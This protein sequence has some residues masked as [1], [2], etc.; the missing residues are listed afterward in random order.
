M[1]VL[2]MVHMEFIAHF[3]ALTWMKANGSKIKRSSLLKKQIMKITLNYLEKM[4][5]Y[6]KTCIMPNWV[7]YNF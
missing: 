2:L 1:L 5:A 7:I 3:F 4:L 6:N